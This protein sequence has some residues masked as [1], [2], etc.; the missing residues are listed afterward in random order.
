MRP[1][2][3]RIVHCVLHSVRRTR[4]AAQW[5]KREM[6]TQFLLEKLRGRSLAVHERIILQ[7]NP[8]C[9]DTLTAVALDS[10]SICRSRVVTENT[11]LLTTETLQDSQLASPDE[12]E[13]PFTI[14]VCDNV[15][16]WRNGETMISSEKQRT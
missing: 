6:Y 10:L 2:G 16:E 8:G 13:S 11:R 7:L 12:M 9:Y 15:M 3:L 5:G 4:L 1:N 14:K